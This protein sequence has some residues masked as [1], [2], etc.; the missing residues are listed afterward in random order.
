MSK[1]KRNWSKVLEIGAEILGIFLSILP[2]I[3]RR[4][5]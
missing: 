5:K 2:F 3:T 1:K 4:K